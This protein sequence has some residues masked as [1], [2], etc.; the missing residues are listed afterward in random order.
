GLNIVDLGLIYDLQVEGRMA[1]VR[2]TMTT[3]AC[4]MSSYIKQQV[5]AVLQRTPGLRR[6][7]VELV[8]DPP[9]SPH[10]IAPEARDGLYRGRRPYC[11]PLPHTP[12][13]TSMN[14]A[15][16]PSPV[17][18]RPSASSSTSAPCSARAVSRSPS[19]WR[20]PAP[21]P[22]ATSSGC[23]PPSSRSPSTA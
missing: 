15:V 1:T 13:P 19:S 11:S 6:G 3:P 20:P 8:W 16:R 12:C 4:P 10:M 21:C 17:S 22:S 2:L 18:P 23:A 7:V 9:W 14:P 5:G